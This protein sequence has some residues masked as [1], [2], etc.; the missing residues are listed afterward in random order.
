MTRPRRAAWVLGVKIKNIHAVYPFE[1]YVIQ[2]VTCQPVGI[3]IK[4]RRD[5]RR[6]LRCPDCGGRMAFNRERQQLAYDLSCGA[7]KVTYVLYPATQGTCSACAG[8]RTVRPAEIH[9]SRGATWRL[10][11]HVSLLARHVPF[12]LMSAVAEVPAATAWRYDKAVL[13]ADLPEPC[14]DGIRAILVDE[15]SVGKGHRYVTLVLDAE[16]GE[17]LHLFEGK[18]KASLDAFFARLTPAQKSTIQ[19]ACIDRAGAY[20]ASIEEHLPGAAIV[21]DKFHLA[22]NLN[23]ALD[24]V[25]REEYREAQEAGKAAIKGQ[26][27]NLLRHPEN[28]PEGRREGLRNLLALNEKISAAYVLKDA[29]RQLWTYSKE[30][31][32]RRY[33]DSWIGWV[34]ESGIAPLQRFANGLARDTQPVLNYFRHPI[35]NGRLEGFNS[36]AAR[37]IAKCR[38]IRSIPYLYLRLRHES[39]LQM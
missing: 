9:P 33:L 15:K 19:A 24:A 39:I 13:E 37:I 27:Y 5:R 1:G 11:R 23:A 30:G 3:Q 8:Y 18:K 10:M 25:R 17:L 31:W 28:I 22:K 35:S 38:G 32:A 4:L 20:R 29:F 34:R 26:R 21:Y 7:G 14:L 2:S 36:I 16:S 6:A 12:R